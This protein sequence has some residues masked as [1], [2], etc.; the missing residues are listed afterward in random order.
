MKLF[1]D[2]VRTYEGL[3]GPRESIYQFLNRSARPEYEATR[4][5]LEKWFQD[6][7]EPYNLDLSKRMCSDIDDWLQALDPDEVVG[8]KTTSTLD[9]WPYYDLDG[10][11]IV[12][13]AIPKP[14]GSRGKPGNTVLGQRSPVQWR[15][16]HNSL[17]AALKEKKDRYGN[18][19]LP[20]VIAI[21]AL[22]INSLDCDIEEIL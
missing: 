12:F 6:Y 16:Q 17:Q 7:P 13:I 9:R 20:Y 14:S 10:W 4:T 19:E 15:K 8:W 11:K 18:F 1:D 2:S 22:A 21:D 5:L 3:R